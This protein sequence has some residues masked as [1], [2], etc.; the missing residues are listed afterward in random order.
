MYVN[1]LFRLG[2]VSKYPVN[3]LPG[4]HFSPLWILSIA[5]VVTEITL[6]VAVNVVEFEAFDRIY[7]SK[8]GVAKDIHK[9]V[10]TANQM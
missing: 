7:R 8:I 4:L 1:I 5:C 10:L 2:M 3:E 9:K 6:L